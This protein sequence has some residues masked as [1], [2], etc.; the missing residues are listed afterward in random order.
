M[1][2]KY[3][4]IVNL[5]PC[6]PGEI[7]WVDKKTLSEWVTF[8]NFEQRIRCEVVGF[9]ITK[10]QILINIRP[11]TERAMHTRSHQFY[12]LSA[13]GLTVFLDNGKAETEQRSEG[14][15]KRD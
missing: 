13:I 2:N 1:S 12:P 5:F 3:D 15:A 4:E 7:V 14:D 9:K 8:L 6:K 11:L 10:K